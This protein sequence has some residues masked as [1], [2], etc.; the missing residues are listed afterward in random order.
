MFAHPGYDQSLRQSIGDRLLEWLFRAL[1]SVLQAIRGY[2][3]IRW[4]VIAL[5]VALV[6][7]ILARAAYLAA[8]QSRPRG[9]R[10]RRRSSGLDP[11][12]AAAGEAAE[13]RFDQAA[14]LLYSAVLEA[15]ARHHRTVL[16][17]AR[18]TGEYERD[19][20]TQGSDALQSFGAFARAYERAVWRG[21]RIDSQAYETLRKLASVLVESRQ[22][23]EAA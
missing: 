1:A 17:P 4:V 10:A 9:G 12:T 8:V 13:G 23:R 22:H 18:T 20:R 15:I 16:H 6:V 5:G 2:T 3:D 14:H 21:S 11:W 7:F 19:L